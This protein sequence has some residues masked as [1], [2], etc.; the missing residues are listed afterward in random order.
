M[1]QVDAEG[2]IP[3]D[4]ELIPMAFFVEANLRPSF[5]AFLPMETLGALKEMLNEPVTLGVLAEEPEEE[6]DEVH[7][8]VGLAVPIDRQRLIE[9]ISGD[10]EESEP[11]RSDAP[12][13]DAWRGDA[14]DDTGIDGVR[15]STALLAFAP[16]VRLQRNF[17]DDF[18][19]ELADL[20]E[21]ALSGA[22]RPANEARVDRFLGGL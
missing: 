8:M 14:D 20:L 16:V 9:Q 21:S 22:T 2:L 7:A 12:S 10:G 13:D 3:D 18:A 19:A 6:G 17:P 11:W 15:P 5:R 4:S 1:E